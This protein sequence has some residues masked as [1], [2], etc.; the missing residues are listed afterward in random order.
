MHFIAFDEVAFSVHLCIDHNCEH[1]KMAEP[2][3]MSFGDRAAWPEG[4]FI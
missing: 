1:C 2:T 4:P 3:E